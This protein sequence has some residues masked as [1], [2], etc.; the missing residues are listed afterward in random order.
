VTQLVALPRLIWTTFGLL[1]VITVC[2]VFYEV[3]R[4]FSPGDAAPALAAG[5]VGLACALLAARSAPRAISE[6]ARVG[7]WLDARSAHASLVAIIGLGVVLRL[8]AAAFLGA[9]IT[10][11]GGVYLRLARGLLDGG[12][13][14]DQRGDI[15]Y[16]PPGYPLLLTAAGLVFGLSEPLAAILAINLASFI[17]AALG[18][19]ALGRWLYGQSAALAAAAILSVWPNLILGAAAAG[20]EFPAL[21]F[22]TASIVLYVDSRRRIGKREQVGMWAAALGCGLTLGIASLIQPALMFLPAAIF[23]GELLGPNTGRAAAFRTVAVIAGMLIAIT[24]WTA[25]N[26]SVLGTPVPISTNGGD[27][28]YRANN[29]LAV[30]G[31][32][33]S[34]PVD[35]RQR[36]EAERSRLGFRLAFEW[37][38]REPHRFL[39][40]SWQRL[41]H[42][43][44]DNSTSA[45]HALRRNEHGLSATYVLAKAV[46]NTAWLSLWLLI[47]IA[48]AGGCA[49]SAAAPGAWSL[50]LSYLYLA[51]IDSVAESG[52]RHHVPFAAVLAVIAASTLSGRC[53]APEPQ[54][55]PAARRHGAMQFIDFAAVG[56][57]GTA[58]HFA[59]LV[60]L[61]QSYG[62]PPAGA[63]TA[64]F[65][66]G[67][68]VNYGLNYR[69][70][71]Q[72]SA[73]HAVALPRFL[74]IAL[75]SMLL[76][77]AIV[78]LLVHWQGKHYLIGQVVA[79]VV[80]LVVNFVANRAL[81]FAAP[82][83]A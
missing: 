15:A 14:V 25:R 5:C 31:F 71:F 81:T 7:R 6:L 20:K 12:D 57:V 11:D 62:W 3:I 59:T 9:E 33:D 70:T 21:A 58:A 38:A 40:L 35:L 66:V 39:V 4:R 73:R 54:A 50:V 17:I 74:A 36:P 52:A 37:I 83:P 19:F 8:I 27:V 75:L 13:Y 32:A 82:R 26:A 72:S 79:T 61:V 67:A 43:S 63:T 42:F 30:P 41:L 24:P 60:V 78:W 68:L 10:S 47:V 76:N 46:S 1:A 34:G 49:Q 45:Y 28:F 44:G 48:L 80:V 29:S 22:L 16:W 77:L 51:A 2:A 23:L 65:L 69:L 64:G 56:I 53:R 55:D 18:A